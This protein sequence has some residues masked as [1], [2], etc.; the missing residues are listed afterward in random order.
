MVVQE[1]ALDRVQVPA[2][3]NVI[4]LATTP[5]KRLAKALA[6]VAVILLAVVVAEDLNTLDKFNY[7]K[8]E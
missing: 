8:G 1:P 6:L 2:L 4:P 5:V 7:M 3:P